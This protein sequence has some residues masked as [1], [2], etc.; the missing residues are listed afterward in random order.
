MILI[1]DALSGTRP[2]Y[3]KPRSRRSIAFSAMSG[4]A[5]RSSNS[6]MQ[7]CG[8]STHPPSPSWLWRACSDLRLSWGC[9]E[10]LEVRSRTRKRIEQ[11][12]LPLLHQQAVVPASLCVGDQGLRC[13]A[14]Q[15]R[16]PPGPVLT[17]AA[18]RVCPIPHPW[19]VPVVVKD[20]GVSDDHDVVSR[21]TRHWANPYRLKAALRVG[22]EER[23]GQNVARAGSEKHSVG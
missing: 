23:K 1:A 22:L 15:V 16:V 5:T 21:V 9:R 20:E 12:V 7:V 6:S 19:A 18:C 11:V 17:R 2:D 13:D 8:P 14:H 3:T 10:L 4:R